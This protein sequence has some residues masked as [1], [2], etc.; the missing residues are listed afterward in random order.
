MV[1]FD[2]MPASIVL[3][4]ASNS[5]RVKQILELSIHLLLG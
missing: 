4:V 2:A 5:L 3:E 1:S